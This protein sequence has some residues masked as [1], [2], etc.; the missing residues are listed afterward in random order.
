MTIDAWT[1]QNYVPLKKAIDRITKHSELSEELLHYTLEVLLLRK[2]LFH[3]VE[4]GEA[5]YMC[6]RI[7]T[8]NW[9]SAN[10]P[11]HR[12]YRQDYLDI[13]TVTEKPDT[14]SDYDDKIDTLLGKIDTELKKLTW[15]EEML[16][17]VYVEHGENAALLSRKTGIPRTSINLTIK[18]VRQHLKNE[19]THE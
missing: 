3:L 18:R 8:N 17:K 15:F 19:I 12:T 6:L 14:D 1:D 9:N 13:S 10:S 2:D 5:W 11:F 4:S 16:L 7:A